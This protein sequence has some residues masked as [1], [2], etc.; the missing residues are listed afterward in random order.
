[1]DSLLLQAFVYLMAAVV[2]VPL[3]RRIGL[4]SVLGYLLAGVFIGPV[5]GLVGSETSDLQ[6][7]AEFGVVMML[8]IIGL[9]LEPRSLWAMRH[10]LLGLGGLQVLLSLLII[11]AAAL[12]LGLD[13]RTALVVGMILSL[14]STAIVL[15]TL[16]EKGL[17]R[18]EG[19]K[20]SF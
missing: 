18:S 4:G 15:Q 13:F 16:N 8:F 5:A 14:S 6:K 3:A 20:A 2:A 10:R 7:F 17:L 19:G 11:T 1:M 12:L 9:E